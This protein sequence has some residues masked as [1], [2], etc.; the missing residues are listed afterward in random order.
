MRPVF[1]EVHLICQ[2]CKNKHAQNTLA[3]PEIILS[4]NEFRHEIKEIF[5]NHEALATSKLPNSDNNS[6]LLHLFSWQ[7]ECPYCKAPIEIEFYIQEQTDGSVYDINFYTLNGAELKHEPTIGL[8]SKS[9]KFKP[10]T[11][12]LNQYMEQLLDSFEQDEFWTTKQCRLRELDLEITKRL[13]TAGF[14]AKYYKAVSYHC[15]F[16]LALIQAEQAPL[17]TNQG[18][19]TYCDQTRLDSGNGGLDSVNDNNRLDSIYGGAEPN[20]NRLDNVYGELNSINGGLEPNNNG[21]D[22]V[23]GELDTN[24]CRLDDANSGVDTNNSG[25]DSEEFLMK[26]DES[27]LEYGN[28]LNLCA[29]LIETRPRYDKHIIDISNILEWCECSSLLSRNLYLIKNQV[30]MRCLEHKARTQAAFDKGIECRIFEGRK[31]LSNLVEAY[32]K[33]LTKQAKDKAKLNKRTKA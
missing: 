18:Q 28:E 17:K 1:S 4:Q 2:S 21:L 19:D 6:V 24:N 23:N 10:S 33:K 5:P 12:A 31:L 30:P 7:G 22:S 8:I 14:E 11:D 15:N 20:N 27:I 26:E 32:Q 29:F 25:L 9:L 3:L 16:I 13:K